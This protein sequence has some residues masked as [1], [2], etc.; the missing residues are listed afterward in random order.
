MNSVKRERFIRVA[1]ARTRKALSMIRL[2]GN[3]ANRAVYEYSESDINKIF[4][5]LEQELRNSKQK[6]QNKKDDTFKLSE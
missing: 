5:T 4:R 2:I 3:C 6:Y 1:E